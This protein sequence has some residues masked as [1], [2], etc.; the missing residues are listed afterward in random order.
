M[1]RI[2]TLLMLV[3][4]LAS[5]ALAQ[6]GLTYRFKSEDGVGRVWVQGDNARREFE[7][8]QNGTAAGRVEIW[9]DGGKQILVLNPASQTYYERNAHLA[10]MG[11]SGPTLQ[12]LT[13]L[14]PFRLQGIED[15]R[16]EVKVSSDKEEVFGYGCR[17]ASLTFSYTMQVSIERVPGTFPAYVHGTEKVCVMESANPPRMPFEHALAI[18][19]SHA[20]V[21]RLI[22]ERLSSLK[23]IPVVRSVEVSRRMQGGEIVYAN[24]ALA[25]SEI[26]PATIPAGHF[27]VPAGYR[28]QEPAI[29]AP[30]RK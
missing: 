26:G 11:V 15:M 29:T 4:S 20:E 14:K 9:K 13:V 10:K 30:V 18:P 6:E 25:L 28:F 2:V 22:A 8:G 24:S 7:S 23:G 21:D 12:A 17:N 19:S 1:P 16:A 5:P 3:L 27:A